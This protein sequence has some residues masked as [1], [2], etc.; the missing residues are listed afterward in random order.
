MQCLSEGFEAYCLLGL[1]VARGKH[2]LSSTYNIMA[3]FYSPACMS[4]RYLTGSL[5]NHSAV[6]ILPLIYLLGDNQ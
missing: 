5:S 1:R 2:E 6:A 4:V 3:A